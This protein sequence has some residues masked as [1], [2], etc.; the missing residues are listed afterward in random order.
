MKTSVTKRPGKRRF[1]WRNQP[2][3]D[4][5]PLGRPRMA[6]GCW[7]SW[8]PIGV[9]ISLHAGGTRFDGTVCCDC[10]HVAPITVAASARRIK[11]RPG[12]S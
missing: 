9:A 6:F 11:A 5:R 2:A 1:R 10:H 8:R 12:F 4:S 3:A 7:R